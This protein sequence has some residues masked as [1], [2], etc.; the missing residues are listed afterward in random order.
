[1]RRLILTLPIVPVGTVAL[2]PGAAAGAEG[3]DSVCDAR[4]YSSRLLT[5]G[6]ASAAVAD[7]LRNCLRCTLNF[8]STF[9]DRSI[10]VNRVCCQEKNTSVWES[11]GRC[12]LEV[13]DHEKINV[14]LLVG[15]SFQ[16]T[17]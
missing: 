5:R 14:R 7:F 2:E 9:R 15:T 11:D 12:H 17:L 6:T 13:L 1:M 3:P 8:I 4:A 16:K 10:S